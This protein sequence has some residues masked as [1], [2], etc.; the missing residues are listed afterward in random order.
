[1]PQ[2]NHLTRSTLF[3]LLRRDRKNTEHFDHNFHDNIGHRISWSNFSVA[4]ET[5]EELF[6]PLEQIDEHT[7][8]CID[9]LSRLTK[10]CVTMTRTKR[11]KTALTK[12]R[13]PIPANMTFAGENTCMIDI[14]VCMIEE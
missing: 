5:F 1:M 7:L 8:T 9:V 13:T 4:L 12:R 11:W 3:D 14:R 6:D 10:A 2:A